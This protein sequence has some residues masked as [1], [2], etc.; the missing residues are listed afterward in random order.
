MLLLCRLILLVVSLTQ[1]HGLGDEISTIATIAS[2]EEREH[3]FQQLSSAEKA[4]IIADSRGFHYT[5]FICTPPAKNVLLARYVLRQELGNGAEGKVD[6]AVDTCFGSRWALK[7]YKSGTAS[8]NKEDQIL[9]EIGDNKYILPIERTIILGKAENALLPLMA[10]GSLSSLT[11]RS[12]NLRNIKEIARQLV[13]AVN[14]I[15]SKNIVHADIKLDNILVETVSP[16]HLRVGDFGVAEKIDGAFGKSRRGAADSWPYDK[17]LNLKQKNRKSDDIWAIG[18]VIRELF[19][20]SIRKGIEKFLKRILPHSQISVLEVESQMEFL[21]SATMR[22]A[23]GYGQAEKQL[24]QYHASE[25]DKLVRLSPANIKKLMSVAK[26]HKFIKKPSSRKDRRLW[27]DFKSFFKSCLNYD[28]NRRATIE[29]L[30][31]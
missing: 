28:P 9:Q 30:R 5:N 2:I 7:R 10:H 31:Q 17:L 11:F 4:S 8:L 22:I 26:V 24:W 13:E 23:T 3:I 21:V 20:A 27:K 14:A 1:T 25:I 19:G 15:H 18:I 16:L 6:V 12:I 29:T